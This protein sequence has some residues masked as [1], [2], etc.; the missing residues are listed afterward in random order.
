MNN[1]S[2]IEILHENISR[3]RLILYIYSIVFLLNLFAMSWGLVNLYAGI[4]HYK[5]LTTLGIVICAFNT[6]YLL[7]NLWEIK[8]DIIMDKEHIVLLKFEEKNEFHYL[9]I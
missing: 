9:L 6:I 2:K 5:L 1:F 7:I 8:I 3:N 4:S